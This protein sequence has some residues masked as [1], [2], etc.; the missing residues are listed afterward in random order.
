MEF[1]ILG[2]LEFS[3]DGRPVSLGG[4]KQRALLALLLL[5]ANRVVSSE[6][7]LD[8]LWGDKP[9]ASGLTA[10]QGRVSQ[11]RRA[12][13]QPGG[14]T[15]GGSML[16]T[17]APGYVLRLDEGRLDAHRF[18]RLLADGKEALARGDPARAV[19]SLREAL[20]LWRGPALADVALE[21]FVQGEIA[22]L[23]ELRLVA[24]ETRIEADLALG[25]H[26]DLVAELEAL[27]A[28]HPHREELRGQLMLA[29]YRSGR[30]AEALEAYRDGRRLL[31][32]TLG[33]EPAEA[34]RRLEAAILRQDP[35]LDLPARPEPAGSGTRV[36]PS[37]SG[38]ERKVVTVL[39][40]DVVGSTELVA[41]QDPERARALLDRLFD[42]LAAEIDEAGGTVEKFIGDAVMAVFGAPVAQ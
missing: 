37:L 33:L 12:L 25:H 34:L 13:E 10:L 11:L 42:A 26:G 4:P 16:A 32:E 17:R 36:A 5:N 23:E 9:P 22:R 1:R 15:E 14:D 2:P 35:A 27:A 6:R 24:L 38:G 3:E 29:L 21:P 19:A 18:E 8:E 7:L 28:Q 39:F 30:Q 31:V 20:A 40:A 41:S